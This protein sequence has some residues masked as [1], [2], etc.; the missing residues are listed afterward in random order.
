MPQHFTGL[1]N[2]QWVLRRKTIPARIQVDLNWSWSGYFLKRQPMQELKWQLVLQL[3]RWILILYWTDWISSFTSMIVADDVAKANLIRNLPDVCEELNIAP[4][5][6][7]VFED[8]PTESAFT[9]QDEL[10]SHLTITTMYSEDEFN[11]QMYYGIQRL[12]I[13]SKRSVI[14]TNGMNDRCRI[15]VDFGTD[16][17]RVVVINATNG[18]ELASSVSWYPRWKLVCI[19]MLHWTSSGS[20]RWIILKTQQSGEGLVQCTGSF[21]NK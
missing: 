3:S 2:V 8:V 17:V 11:P 16:S 7:L 20:I 12:T 13:F 9:C 6:C 18:V 21:N 10:C 14:K 4:E 1:R 19:A 15:G 5:D